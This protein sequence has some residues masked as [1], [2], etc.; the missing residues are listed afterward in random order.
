M[1]WVPETLEA[2]AE[3]AAGLVS[4]IE[5]VGLLAAA[6]RARRDLGLARWKGDGEYW[7][8]LTEELRARLGKGFAAAWAS[9][10]ALSLDEAIG[11]ARRARGERKRPTIGWEALTPTEQRI[12]ELATEGL[13]NPQIGERMFISRTTVKT[14][15]EHIYAKVGVHGRTELAAAATAR[16]AERSPT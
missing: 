12:V 5:A 11:W 2:L 7:T 8:P 13:T 3:V 9:G 1:T 6:A 14:H 15:L 16:Q 10:D 4:D